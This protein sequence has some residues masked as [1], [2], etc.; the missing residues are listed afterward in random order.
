ME[1]A[2]RW[3]GRL[4][5]VGIG[6][7]IVVFMA[8]LFVGAAGCAI[9]S[10]LDWSADAADASS[11]WDPNGFSDFMNKYVDGTGKK[12]RKPKQRRKDAGRRR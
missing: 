3:I 10:C 9:Q 8:Y 5:K 4:A 7:G 6:I 1:T 11:R 2:L 12:K